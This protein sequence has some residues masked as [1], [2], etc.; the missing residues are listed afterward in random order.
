MNAP[1][2]IVDSPGVC[3]DF[4][5]KSLEHTSRESVRLYRTFFGQPIRDYWAL[6]FTGHLVGASFDEPPGR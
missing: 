4:L 5:A 6:S 3:L 2:S 1:R